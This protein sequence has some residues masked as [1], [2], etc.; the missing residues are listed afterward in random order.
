MGAFE[1]LW[2]AIPS[3]AQIKG[4][5]STFPP[6]AHAHVQADVAGLASALADLSTRQTAQQVATAVADAING[7]RNGAPAALDTLKEIADKFAAE[8]SD[9]AAF[10]A[11]LAVR[12]RVDGAQSLT[13][14]QQQQGRANLGLGTAA[15]TSASAFAPAGSAPSPATATPSAPGTANAGS[16]AKYARED[17]AHPS[18]VIV[19]GAPTPRTVAFGTPLQ[20]TDKTKPARVI[21]NLRA[22]YTVTLA[23]LAVSDNIELRIGASDVSLLAASN[24]TGVAVAPF[25]TGVS[26]IAVVVGLTIMQ[27]DQLIADLPAG[28]WFGLR[29]VGGTT[30]TI[31]SAF[32]QTVS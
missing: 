22:A 28:W 9:H 24:P 7:L 25:E 6:A 1:S 2:H 27:R 10:L 21:V 13:S 15:T 11:A 19:V 32:E 29:R 12:L 31:A 16:S 3:W 17:H 8:D 14:A 26:G 23:S 18:Q 5:P 20:A 30:A 4:K